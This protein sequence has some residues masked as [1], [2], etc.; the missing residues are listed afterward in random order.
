MYAAKASG[1]TMPVS[2]MKKAKATFTMTNTIS[3]PLSSHLRLRRFSRR[4]L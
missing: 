2:L 4:C 1:A 3:M